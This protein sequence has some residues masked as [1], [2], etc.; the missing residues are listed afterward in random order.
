LLKFGVELVPM[1]PWWKTVYYAVQAENA[2]FDHLWVTDHFY[3]Q[4]LWVTL[5]LIANYTSKI[6]L[7]PAATNPYVFHPV[8]IAQA[9]LTLNDLAPERT[10]C[11]V[12]RGDKVTLK[13]LRINQEDPFTTLKEAVDIIRTVTA[14]DPVAADGKVFKVSGVKLNLGPSNPIPLY[15]G[16]Q[17]PKMLSLAGEVG[18]GVLIDASLPQDVKFSMK[19]VEDGLRRSPLV[20]AGFDFAA[21]TVTSI[22]D[23]AV[24]AEKAV[25]HVLAFIVSGSPSIILK[26][27]GVSQ[28]EAS[29]IRELIMRERWVEALSSITPGMVEGFSICGTP[30]M[31]VERFAQL[32]K[33]GVDQIVV[34]SPIGP[35]VKKSIELVEKKVFPH[36]RSGC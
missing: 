17:G 26:R 30:D 33:Q 19:Y 7:G 22:D 24:E 1:S 21:Y 10:V 12:G 28:E 29:R 2:G 20:K 34:G 9:V 3:N 23:N 6:K 25:R 8:L 32:S 14:G 27:H 36:F 5:S 16:A 4:N 18:D 35:V 31:V 13:M 11:G 15:V